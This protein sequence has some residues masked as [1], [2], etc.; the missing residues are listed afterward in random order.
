MPQ[1]LDKDVYIVEDDVFLGQLLHEQFKSSGFNT[2]LITSGDKVLGIVQK[3]VPDLLLLDIFLPGMNGLDVLD[4]LR[5]DK[6]TKHVRVIVVSNTDQID[7]RTRAKD[8]GAD[9]LMKAG[10]TPDGIV[11]FAKKKLGIE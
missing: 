7:S 3:K 2:E 10:T 5:K 1:D 9:F 4:Q 8:L 6:D 11:D